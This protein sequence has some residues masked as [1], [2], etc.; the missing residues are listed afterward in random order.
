[1][2]VDVPYDSGVAVEFWEDLQHYIALLS[3]EHACAR[4]TF[5][6]VSQVGS[7]SPVLSTSPSLQER[8]VNGFRYDK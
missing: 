3:F 8:E 2:Q 4:E 6:T 1:M 5:Y 7:R